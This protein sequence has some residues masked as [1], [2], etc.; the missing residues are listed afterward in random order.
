LGE[1]DGEAKEI[2]QATF[3]HVAKFVYNP[4]NWEK[5]KA[6]ID[7]LQVLEVLLFIYFLLTTHFLGRFLCTKHLTYVRVFLL[8]LTMQVGD[9]LKR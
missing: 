9:Q 6:L 7:L 1:K 8:F 3:Q 4:K 5:K 2:E